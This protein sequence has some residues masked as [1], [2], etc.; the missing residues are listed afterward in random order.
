M[1][2]WDLATRGTEINLWRWW[3]LNSFQRA[4]PHCSRRHALGV[5]LASEKNSL[6]HWQSSYLPHPE[7]RPFQMPQYHETHASLGHHSFPHQFCLF[8]WI[9][10]RPSQHYSWLSLPFADKEIPQHRAAGRAT[11][12]PTSLACD[13]Q[14]SEAVSYYLHTALSPATRAAYRTGAT[15]YL[16]FMA[17]HNSTS[18]RTLPPIN[19]EILCYFVSHC[20]G[21]LGLRHTTIKSYLCGIRNLYIEAG[22]GNPIIMPSGQEISKL[23][24]VLRGIKKSQPQPIRDRLPITPSLLT[25]LFSL[26]NGHFANPFTDNL[27]KAACALAFFGFLRCGE[28][29]SASR[30]FDP[31]QNLTLNDLTLLGLDTQIT[32]ARLHLKASKTDPFRQGTTI[33]LFAL[34][35]SLC[36]IRA[37]QAY[38]P[39]RHLISRNPESPLL[40]L[41]DGAPLSRTSFLN[42]LESA[43]QA[44]GLD[45]KRF[46]GH[47]FRIG[48]ASWAAAC[49]VPDHIIKALG[50]WASPCYQIYIK[51]STHLLQDAH[52][53][54]AASSS[55]PTPSLLSTAPGQ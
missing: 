21:I 51:T 17:M 32:E 28:F 44:L 53:R 23:Q 39:Y 36:P 24:L 18:P 30:A 55:A 16:T 13:V 35:S 25:A 45:D 42:M 37:I 7:Q 3:L 15:T 27:M 49:K 14:L 5:L 48:A 33:A 43:L 8:S 26:W 20:A 2:L 46:T 52:Q 31:T 50:R 47:S 9:H 54:M 22:L 29:T 6:P 10:P 4:I 19:E 34:N 11:T 40:T 12:L 41:P 38:L 1:V